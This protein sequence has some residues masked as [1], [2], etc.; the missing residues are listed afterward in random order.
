[1]I[2]CRSY[3]SLLRGA[4]SPGALVDRAR[5]LGMRWLALADDE[6]LYGAVEFWKLCR[7]AGI[8]PVLGARVDGRVYLVRHRAGYAAL[9]R[10]ITARKLGT[11]PPADLDGLLEPPRVEDVLFATPEGFRVHRLLS[12]IRQNALAA[13]VEGLGSPEACLRP[14]T[15][16]EAERIAEACDW[17]FLPAPKVFP[18]GQGGPERLRALCERGLAWRYP[19]NP[20]RER[21]ERELGVIGKLGY[22]DYFLV[23]HDIVRHSRERGVPVAGRGSGAS[24]LV[25]YVLG[26]TNV[27]P[28]AYG[29]PFERFLHEGRTDYPDLDVDFCWRIRDGVLA[30]VFDR[31]PDAAMVSTHITFQERSA[32]REAA[33]AF[34]YSD[35]QVSQMQRGRAE[36]PDLPKLRA[37]A[38]AILGFPRHLSVHCGGVVLHPDGV[39]PLE[40]AE[41]GVLVT[42]YDKRSVE[43]AGLV[44]IDLLGNRALSAIRETVEIVER[45]TGERIDVEHLPEDAA[46]TRLLHEGR[47]LGCN[48]LESPG[49]RALLRMMRPRGVKGL[50]QA[51]A[52]IR[53][54]AASLGMKDRFI[55]RARGLEPSPPDPLLGDTHG[56]ML[57]EDDAM[58]VASALAGV[59]L[60]E[61]DRFRRRVQKLRTDG[62]RLA[63]SREFLGLCAK[64]GTPMEL[65]KDLWVQMAKFSRFSFCRAHAASYAV[66]AWASAWLAAHHP[67]ARWV[68]ALNNNQ[69]LYDAR[70]YLEQAKREGIRVLL[71]CVQ[72]SGV[73]FSEEGGAIRAGLGRVFGLER[74]ETEAILEGRPFESL[75]DFLARAKISWPSMRNLVLSGALDWTGRPRP[76]VLM[77]AR[78]KGRPVPPVPDFTEEEKFAHEFSILGISAR[79]HPLHYCGLGPREA[80][81]RALA[82]SAGRRLRLAG[83]MA[84]ARITETLGLE[85]MEFL[86]LEDEHGLFEAVLFPAAF[87]RFS[88]LVGTLG[89][90]VVEGRV[91]DRHGAVTIS[92]DRI[93]PVV[94]VPPCL[95]GAGKL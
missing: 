72:R 89:P 68:A 60:P 38:R 71:P 39:A 18:R 25:A 43:E 35:G 93:A 27:C 34:G 73:E 53:P 49:M 86:T 7:A 1:M 56:I 17:E 26:I 19:S 91:E 92:A 31:F 55:R 79:R 45:T 12:A 85:P 3:Y 40:R 95:R 14:E 69:G 50:M 94:P 11:P 9:C 15:G 67:A 8:R 48:Q 80:D 87:R 63:V 74:R 54:G 2:V 84:T 16:P 24:S 66:L 29:L 64:H 46:T 76:Q 23:V 51:L 82:G 44:K 47:T 90:Y 32:F 4:S 75:E 13:H 62:E 30:S 52:L 70:V 42:Q 57:Y 21:L 81:S 41:K 37:A 5:E 78:A 83:I 10:L 88:R 61:G 33:R 28:V 36:P 65:A 77:A 22:A 58:L 20:P 59:S 6:G